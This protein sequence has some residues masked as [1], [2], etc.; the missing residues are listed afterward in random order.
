MSNRLLLCFSLILIL[1]T[2]CSILQTDEP[3]TETRIAAKIFATQT[4]SVPTATPTPPM[5]CPT[6]P[7]PAGDA[8]SAGQVY[9]TIIT[10][11]YV[12]KVELE[13]QKGSNAP[14][15]VVTFTDDGA[16]IFGDY[17][18]KN[19]G[20]YMGIVVNKK[21]IETPIIGSPIYSGIV[22]INGRFTLSDRGI[23]TFT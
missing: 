20:T 3:A 2:A 15:I 17:T 19:V 7:A 12:I 8:G 23:A 9:R 18:V 5:I 10:G 1:I 11:K 21:L 6:P 16:R 13:Y 22:T 4:A 14:Y